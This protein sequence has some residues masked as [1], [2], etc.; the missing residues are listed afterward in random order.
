MRS[1]KRFLVRINNSQKSGPHP[2]SPDLGAALPAPQPNSAG[3]ILGGSNS[4]WD[5]LV[6]TDPNRDHLYFWHTS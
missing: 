3:R 6:A 1:S 4:L 5:S 2:A